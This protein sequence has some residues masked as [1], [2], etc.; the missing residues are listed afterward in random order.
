MKNLTCISCPIGCSLTVEEGPPG[1][2]GLPVLNIGGNRCPR[3]AAYAR[4]EICS[5]KRVVT[6]TCIIDTVPEDV[7][8]RSL[9]A[10]RRLPVKS[11]AACPR[12]KIDELL[13]DIYR[14]GVKLPVKAGD[15][16]IT[17]WKGMGIDVV[18]VRSIEY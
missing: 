9:Y 18:A 5:P 12:D 10:P 16:I 11:A 1:E 14:T 2:D 15:R 6:A 3:G 4:D 17:N 7:K 13:A 8:K